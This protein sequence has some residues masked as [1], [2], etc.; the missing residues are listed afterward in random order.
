[1]IRALL[2]RFRYPAQ[3]DVTAVHRMTSRQWSGIARRTPTY[4]EAYV[5]HPGGSDRAQARARW[6]AGGVLGAFPGLR[7]IHEIGC[8]AGRNLAELR[9]LNPDLRLSGEDICHEAVLA[10]RQTLGANVPILEG[11]LVDEIPVRADV[12]LSV[13][14]LVH[15]HPKLLPEVLAKLWRAAMRGLVLVEEPGHGKVA[16]GPASWGA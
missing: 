4:L 9:R 1:M 5:D 15:I 2:D 10:A 3:D 6:L 8:G 7:S 13:G 12:L 14:V 16:K 11:D